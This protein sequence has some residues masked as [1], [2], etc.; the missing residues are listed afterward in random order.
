MD[1]SFLYS[2]NLSTCLVLGGVAWLAWLLGPSS[3]PAPPKAGGPVTTGGLEIMIHTS[4]I[5]YDISGC[6]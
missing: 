3:K 2:P 4:V 6:H 5:G 1:L